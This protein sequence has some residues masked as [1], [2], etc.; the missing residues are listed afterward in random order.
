MRISQGSSPHPMT[1]WHIRISV[2]KEKRNG[3]CRVD[4]PNPKGC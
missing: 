3:R 2:D 4:V 1:N